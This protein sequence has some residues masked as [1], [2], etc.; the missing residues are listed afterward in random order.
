[1]VMKT[2]LLIVISIFVVVGCGPSQKEK[3]RIAQVACAEI[4]ETRS[5]DSAPRVRVVNEAREKLGLDPF[6]AGD[7][8]ITR[9]IGAGTCELLVMASSNYDEATTEAETLQSLLHVQSTVEECYSRSALARLTI[10]DFYDKSGGFPDPYYISQDF[11]E[12]DICKYKP[13]NLGDFEID[14]SS[15]DLALIKSGV[16]QMVV[17]AFVDDPNATYPVEWKCAVGETSE[18]NLIFLP[19]FCRFREVDGILFEGDSDTPFTGVLQGMNNGRV[20]NGKKEGEWRSFYS[21]GQLKEKGF[22]KNGSLIGEWVTYHENGQV[23]HKGSYKNGNRDGEWVSYHENGQVQ[24]RYLI[25]DGREEGLVQ[26]WD[27][28]G[29]LDFEVCVSNG[30]EV[31]ISQCKK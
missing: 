13:L 26:F 14:I 15:E 10:S 21:S 18:Q 25:K 2:I 20:E 16:I 7:E 31:D 12:T 5:M 19:F 6:L 28:D 24:A 11:M 4:R 27:E 17:S 3:N 23:E 29:I 22:Y 8:E 30:E 1:M 9:S